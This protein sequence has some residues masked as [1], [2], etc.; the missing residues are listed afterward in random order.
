MDQFLEKYSLLK[1]TQDEIE[2]SD[3]YYKI[4]G[5][6]SKN[7]PTNKIPRVAIQFRM[8]FNLYNS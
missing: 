4:N 5:L 2:K 7:L 6:N 1:L 3:Y 8:L